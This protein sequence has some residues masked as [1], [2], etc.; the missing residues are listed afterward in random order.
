[1]F[2]NPLIDDQCEEQAERANNQAKHQQGVPID[3]AEERGLTEI[4]E[5]EIRFTCKGRDFKSQS[6]GNGSS[7]QEEDTP[8]QRHDSANLRVKKR[9]FRTSAISDPTSPEKRRPVY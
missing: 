7:E 9:L 3:S 2:R 6:G 1:M 4:G 5:L 8:Q